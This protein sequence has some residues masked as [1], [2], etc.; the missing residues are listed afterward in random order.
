[1]TE[2]TP[3]TTTPTN[4]ATTEPAA[5]GSTESL[6][7]AEKETPP[8]QKTSADAKQTLTEKK[9]TTREQAPSAK[10]AS[11]TQAKNRGLLLRGHA[12]Q[13]AGEKTSET[14]E[15]ATEEK[16]G[17]QAEYDFAFPED[18]T[19]DAELLKE[20][21]LF[22]GTHK[23]PPEEA[24]RLADL[25]VRLTRKM[26]QAQ[27]QAWETTIG[28]WVQALPN[29][30]VFGGAAFE[31]NMAIARLPF[32]DVKMREKFGFELVPI[33][34]RQMLDKATPSNPGGLGFSS[35]PAMI[36]HFYNLGRLLADDTP[37]LGSAAGG[38]SNEAMS[39]EDYFASMLPNHS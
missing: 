29:H 34:L 27:V 15:G 12:D 19:P 9:T 25:G 14:A 28:N 20:L 30:P 6:L 22:A 16:S 36:H 31:K 2:M 4:P 38:R 11:E 18:F 35:H 39:E 33:E 13:Q 8:A 24:Q 7:P 23:L 21:K 10:Q 3:E 17:D 5:S 37:L 26:Q 32:D 1:M